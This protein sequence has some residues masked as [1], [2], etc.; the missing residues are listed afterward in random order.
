MEEDWTGKA[1]SIECDVK[2][3][4]FQGIISQCTP[5]EITIVRAFRNGVPL[6]K[7]DAEV[8]LRSSD[9]L[10]ISLIPSYNGQSTVMP[11]VINKPTPV[12]QPNFSNVGTALT[13]QM[14]GGGGGVGTQH[15]QPSQ[16]QD[17]NSVLSSKMTNM[18]VN[19]QHNG[20]M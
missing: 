6:R 9:I 8:T 19:S 15:N 18:K 12:K 7:Q 20:I 14:N 16:K 11:T 17:V 13:Q 4:V 3:G 1:V 10:K 5:S 2:L